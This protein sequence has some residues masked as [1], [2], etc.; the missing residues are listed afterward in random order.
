MAAPT[1]TNKL[2]ITLGDG[3]DPE[4]FAHPCGANSRAL[5]MTNNM[6]EEALLDCDDP[7]GQPAAIYRWLESQ[8]T[9]IELS[10]R[11]SVSSFG[12]WRAWSDSGLAKNIRIE[13]MNNTT[14]G[15]GY[16]AIPAI[17]GTF[18]MTGEGKGTI[19]FTASISASGPRVWT[20][21]S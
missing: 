15:G 13:I 8:D 11:V 1:L 9:S 20:D 18:E 4:V 14:D 17:L 5:T 6:G 10:G 3:A 12:V 2:L 19:T 16:Y 7:L 21:A